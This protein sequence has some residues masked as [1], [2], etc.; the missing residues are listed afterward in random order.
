VDQRFSD[1]GRRLRA[2]RLGS[3]LRAAQVA[4]LLGISRSAVYRIEAG[5]VVKIETLERLA[6]VLNTSTASLLG[7]GVEYYSKAVAYFERMRQLE[8]EA[9]LVLVHFAPVSY[10]LT[11]AAYTAYLRQMLIEALPRDTGATPEA[12]AEIETLIGILKERKA[13]P[14]RP[15]IV[16]L[17]SVPEIER[18]L[19]L[20]LIGRFDLPEREWAS[21]REAA[22]H[23]VEH[24]MRLLAEEPEGVQLG[25]IEE[26]LPN[27]TFQ[28]FRRPAGTVLA[29]SPFRLGEQP[30][31]R[32]GVATVTSAEEP[33][34]LYGRL[35]DGLWRGALK[36][37]AAAARLGEIVARTAQ[38]RVRAQRA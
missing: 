25:L 22:R 20:G 36:G 18:F 29:V 1:I 7:V 27:V 11:T 33:V 34:G 10:L 16:N 9:D 21:R 15:R 28:L 12:M 6:G 3:G 37:E 26:T 30:N 31:I 5:E 35:V 24:I 4:D 19:E 2:Y 23:E 38:Q 32:Y 8:E 14:R 17:I 13:A